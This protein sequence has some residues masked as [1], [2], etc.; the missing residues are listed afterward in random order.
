M[1]E[2]CSRCKYILQRQE[3][4]REEE[5]KR[6]RGRGRG[7]EEEEEEEEA[8]I[9]EMSCVNRLTQIGGGRLFTSKCKTVNRVN[10]MNGE[11]ADSAKRDGRC[12]GTGG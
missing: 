3:R 11:Q 4:E 9:I 8:D 10:G 2:V 12:S 7:R 1:G 6:G 5:K